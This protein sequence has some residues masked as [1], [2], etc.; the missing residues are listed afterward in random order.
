MISKLEKNPGTAAA[1]YVIKEGIPEKRLKYYMVA[2]AIIMICVIAIYPI[3]KTI[4]NSFFEMQLQDLDSTRFIGMQ[5]YFNLFQDETFVGCLK[6]TVY[7]TFF[8]VILE[9]IIGFAAALLMNLD[10][11]GRGLL[12]AAILIPWA[13]PG[14]IIALIWQ[15]MFND[16]LGIIN[17]LLMRAHIIKEPIVWLGT[18]GYAMW[19][20]IVA[21]VWKQVPF[22]AL[23]LVAGLQMVP[24]E[25]YEA[26]AMD[27]AGAFNKFFR[28]TI[29]IM[30]PII[31]VA[32]LFRTM[33][34]FRIFDTIYGMTGG[35]PGDSTASITMYAYKS[36]FNN[37]DWGYGS[38]VAVITFIIIFML[39]LLYI[40]VLGSKDS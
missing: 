31:L 21:D 13:I 10:F 3:S 30:K 28:I 35:G 5:N 36:L 11:K 9:L 20:V 4:Y 34:A 26:A 8:S 27:G 15:F 39:C 33:G 22:M 38:A 40:K 25:M 19:A 17:D 24:T 37:L 18:H 1:G 23:L 32:L 29:P 6:N 16:Q 14:I 12:R 7:F 2:P